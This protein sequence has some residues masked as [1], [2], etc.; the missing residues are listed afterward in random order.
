MYKDKYPY[1]LPTIEKITIDTKALV[2]DKGTILIGGLKV[3]PVDL[4][5]PAGD[6]AKSEAKDKQVLLVLVKPTIVPRREPEPDAIAVM[7]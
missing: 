1:E 4:G 2:A 6:V 7:E 5:Q 3:T